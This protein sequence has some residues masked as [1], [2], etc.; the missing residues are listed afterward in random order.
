LSSEDSAVKEI[1]RLIDEYSEKAAKARSVW[2]ALQALSDLEKELDK[3]YPPP[4]RGREGE[5]Q[6]KEKSAFSKLRE[7]FGK[8]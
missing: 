1:E 8:R 4:Q 3:Y 2:E 7:L 6:K 5:K